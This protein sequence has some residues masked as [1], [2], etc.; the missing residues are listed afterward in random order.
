VIDV[1]I[2]IL[3]V[4]AAE[5]VL[6][7]RVGAVV[8]G[9]PV[10]FILLG[11]GVAGWLL[12]RSRRAAEIPQI[13]VSALAGRLRRDKTVAP[14]SQFILGSL[15]LILPGLLSDIAGVVLLVRYFT[16]RRRSPR[17][18]EPGARRR[19]TGS[20]T[21]GETIDVDFKVLDQNDDSQQ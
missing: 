19:G 1:P 9:M 5:V 12:L 14:E 17:G 2:L 4:A 13:I 20:R 8:G 16:Q 21:R 7:V 10:L 6:L 18:P 3:L 15:L 11:T